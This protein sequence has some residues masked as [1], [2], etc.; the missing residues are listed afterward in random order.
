MAT[1]SPF[2]ELNSNVDTASLRDPFAQDSDDDD[3]DS[4]VNLRMKRNG[5][6]MD[7]AEE[8]KDKENISTGLK[9]ATAGAKKSTKKVVIRR[10]EQ[11]KLAAG[12][13]YLIHLSNQLGSFSKQEKR[14]YREP[15]CLNTLKIISKELQNDDNY[16]TKREKIMNIN[17]IKHDLVQIVAHLDTENLKKLNNNQDN[18]DDSDLSDGQTDEYY[19]KKEIMEMQALM[20]TNLFSQVIRLLVNLTQ[21]IS[22]CFRNE[23][24]EGGNKNLD[25]ISAKR[26]IEIARRN[27]KVSFLSSK[28]WEKFYV[29]FVVLIQAQ[30]GETDKNRKKR[31]EERRRQK[32][33]AKVERQKVRE[34]KKAAKA[35][36]LA[37]K[38][39]K[40]ADKP[41]KNDSDSNSDTDSNSSIDMSESSDSNDDDE[42]DDLSDD[43]MAHLDP[44]EQQEQIRLLRN[45]KL[46]LERCLI[47]LKNLLRINPTIEENDLGANLG[48]EST[49]DKLIQLLADPKHDLLTLFLFLMNSP[50]F[51][52]YNL[53]LLEILV[54]LF[55]EQRDLDKLMD[56][57]EDYKEA[58][59]QE[60]RQKSEELSK[61]LVSEN[62]Q[63]NI[64]FKNLP[65]RHNRF[66]GTFVLNQNNNNN[67]N[68]A[69][70]TNFK[71]NSKSMIQHGQN[72]RHNTASFDTLKQSRKIGTKKAMK[73]ES[74]Q[75]KYIQ[76]SVKTRQILKKF[77]L[78]ILE[79]YND[80][81]HQIKFMIKN[82]QLD[83]HDQEVLYYIFAEYF[84]AIA[85]AHNSQSS[86]S[87]NSNSKAKSENFPNYNKNRSDVL[88]SISET[89][90]I[91]M[92]TSINSYLIKCDEGMRSDKENQRTW[93]KRANS[94]LKCYQ[95]LLILIN[96]PN[97]FYPEK[98]HEKFEE[99]KTQIQ[100]A[101]DVIKRNCL[102]VPEYREILPM[103]VRN[104]NSNY[105]PK[106]L[107][108][109]Y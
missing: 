6:K 46:E 77:S 36:K 20:D 63:R 48:V 62:K 80:F 8:E 43:N 7:E 61:L 12:K 3:D 103:L 10:S 105:S 108:W 107:V 56:T 19:D 14:Y 102:Y 70:G 31:L 34:E 22:A 65:S 16:N 25:I 67:K 47:F 41:E 101:L 81:M 64:N 92:I 84:H 29:R 2:K 74:T 1:R 90:S 18:E 32:E 38:E 93:A 23:S 11:E 44:Y 50:K 59:K 57:S 54:L 87:S 85:L 55:K 42:N 72:I 49:H 9:N 109:G 37:E 106:E 28:F 60:L 39:Q 97:K 21:N 78:Q 79:N 66:G 89:V 73:D 45:Q 4:L 51:Q 100:K 99:M 88:A 17:I 76:S 5:T 96:T 40:L 33:I 83:D 71:T 68:K 27:C 35:K 98:D 26:N 30:T 95:K 91:E 13:D 82:N 53:H 86:S 75:N 52:V 69:S 15:D 104:Y 24:E 94:V 58:K